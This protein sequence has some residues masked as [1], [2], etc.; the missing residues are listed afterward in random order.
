MRYKV[1]T[2]QFL[3]SDATYTKK[4]ATTISI[5]RS[6]WSPCSGSFYFPSNCVRSPSGS[7]CP[8]GCPQ[9]MQQRASISAR[10]VP[11]CMHAHT[12]FIPIGTDFQLDGRTLTSCMKKQKG[13]GCG[14]QKRHGR[15]WRLRHRWWL[16][17]SWQENDVRWDGRHGERKT[18]YS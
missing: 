12:R 6:C 14:Y 11:A 17:R 18:R 7:T 5:R 1:A 9:P 4:S 3:S 16:E 8:A 15:C 10:V 13:R 2:I